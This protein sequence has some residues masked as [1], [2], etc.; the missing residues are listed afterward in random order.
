MGKRR[1]GKTLISISVIAL[2]ILNSSMSVI[3]TPNEEVITN[4]NAEATEK[5]NEEVIANQEKYSELDKIIDETQ[6]EIYRINTE[7]DKFTELI[8]KNDE[9]LKGVSSEVEKSKEEIK[10]EEENLKE[11][12]EMLTKRLRE[13]YKS[14]GQNNYILMVLTAEGFTDFISKMFAANKMVDLD[15]KVISDLKDKQEELEESI[16]KLEEKSNNI[17]KAT[18]ENKKALEEI[19]NKKKEQELLVAKVLEERSKFDGEYLAVSERKLVEHQLKIVKESTSLEELHVVIGQ[20]INIRDKQL[21]SPTVIEEINKGIVEVTKRVD[22]LEKYLEQIGTTIKE[23]TLSGNAIVSYA[24]QLLGKPYVFGAIGPDE[25]D[26]SGFTKYVYDKVVGVDITR[27]TYTQIKQGESIPL[28]EL[29]L[30]DLVFTYGVD[31]VGIYVGGGSYIHAPQPGEAI[32][33]SQITSF[34]EGRRIIKN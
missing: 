33:V 25:F 6:G 26:C 2:V 23:G 34:T 28:S 1:I 11:Q 18:E 32:K 9:E 22:G 8:K 15:K 5:N 10:K 17:T 19:E 13:L 4:P 20:L 7:I 31:H 14:G 24:Y 30:G 12:E 21:K 3:A 29:K 27:T 16:N